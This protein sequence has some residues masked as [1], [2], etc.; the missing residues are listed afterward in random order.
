[1]SSDIQV[2]VQ[3]DAVILQVTESVAPIVQITETEGPAIIE[4][5]TPGPPGPQGVQG[6]PGLQGPQGE[7]G[8][9]FVNVDG[10][11]ADSNYGGIPPLDGGGP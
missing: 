4:A 3:T 7:P 5:L 1:V 9:I 10:G 6:P 2:L 8:E 11:Q